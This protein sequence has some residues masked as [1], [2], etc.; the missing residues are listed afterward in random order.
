MNLRD[1]IEAAFDGKAFL[2]PLFY[3]YPGGLRFELSKGGSPLERFLV[4][5]RKATTICADIFPADK[6][7]VVCLRMV[8]MSSLFAHRKLLL[9]LRVA[10]ITISRVRCLWLEEASQDEGFGNDKVS[11][12]HIAFETSPTLLQNCLWCALAADIGSI[13]PRPL[14][15][16][17]LFNLESRV[18]VFPYDDRG[19]DVVGSNP[20]LL[21]RIYSKHH[22]H[23]LIYDRQTM[24]VAFEVSDPSINMGAPPADSATFSEQSPSP[25]L[26]P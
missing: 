19:M 13:R 21:A 1:E 4:A 18:M 3:S 10:G 15:D 8:A 11:W 16:I 9:E 23:L 2:R 25:R 14:C 24:A 22:Q 6:P 20:A 17:Y 26:V 7:M 5:L 12:L